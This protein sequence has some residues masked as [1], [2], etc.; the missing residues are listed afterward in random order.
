QN[1]IDRPGFVQCSSK[2]RHPGLQ[3]RSQTERCFRERKARNLAHHPTRPAKQKRAG[4]EM[5]HRH[6]DN[7]DTAKTLV[8]GRVDWLSA[9]VPEVFEVEGVGG[10]NRNVVAIRD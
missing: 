9:W 5:L 8:G 6:P 3:A 10:N 2:L 4:R 1:R 7:L